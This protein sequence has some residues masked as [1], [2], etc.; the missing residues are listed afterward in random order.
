MINLLKDEEI[1]L[2]QRRHWL[3]FFSELISLIFLAILPF[4][5][6]AFV[7]NLPQNLKD[8]IINYSNY[9]FFFT[10]AFLFILWIFAIIFWTNYYLDILIITNKRIIDIEQ[11]NIFSRDQAEMDFSAIQDIKIE[12]NGI[13]ESIFRFGNI[14]IQSAGQGREFIIKSISHPEKIKDVIY[15][16]K[17]NLK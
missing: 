2:I 9:Y 13:F 10:F 16:Q 3:P 15:A 1:I 5:I 17:N 4:I 6:F 12:T 7:E 8:S 14:Y 11:I